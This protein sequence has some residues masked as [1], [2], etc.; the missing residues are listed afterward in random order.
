[1]AGSQEDLDVKIMRKRRLERS[2]HQPICNSYT[3]ELHVWALSAALGNSKEL[4]TL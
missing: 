2:S 3:V 4:L 1:V